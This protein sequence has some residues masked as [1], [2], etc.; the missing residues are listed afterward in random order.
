MFLLAI[1]W[2]SAFR[3][4]Y[5]SFSPMP[6]S[7][8]LFTA[9]CKAFSDNHFALLHFFFLEMVLNTTSCTMLWTSIHSSS[10]TLSIRSNPLNIFV[11]STVQ[12]QG[13][14]FRSY[15]H[16]LVIFPTFF[17]L[18]LNF[19]IRISWSKPRSAPSLVFADCIEL[20]H[21]QLQII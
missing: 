4:M 20:L 9:L 12:L 14:W 5:L 16:G 3:W 13:I 10:G 15:L 7:S 21:L 2:N 1:L 6:F 8:L 17:N 19:A 18:L 11:T